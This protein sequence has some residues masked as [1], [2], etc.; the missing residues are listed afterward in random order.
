MH[1]ILVI[2]PA[3][4]AEYRRFESTPLVQ[5]RAEKYFSFLCDQTH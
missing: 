3:N 1:D 4:G 2:A 5:R